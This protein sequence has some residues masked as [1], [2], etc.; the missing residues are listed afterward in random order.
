MA[1]RTEREVLNM[2]IETCLDG[3]KGF[4]TAA[5]HVDDPELRTMFLQFAAE[6]DGF[7]AELLPYAQRLG[8]AAAS[9]GTHVGTLHRKWIDVKS[10][11]TQHNDHAI[12]VEVSRGER[13]TVNIYKD[14]IEGLLPPQARDVIER[15]FEVFKQE[16]EKLA[17][18][19]GAH[20]KA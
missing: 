5:G 19:A 7:A 14:A 11:L 6:R 20:A 12:V 1:E 15:Q 2:L 4:K 8:G 10:A 16:H 17:E 13:S 3:A 18:V 9:D